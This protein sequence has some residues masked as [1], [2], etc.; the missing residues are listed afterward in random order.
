VGGMGIAGASVA[1]STGM[2]SPVAHAKSELDRHASCVALGIAAAVMRRAKL[3]QNGS[4][5]ALPG[6]VC[7]SIESEGKLWLGSTLL[8]GS[9]M[10]A[11][12]FTNSTSW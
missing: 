4:D 7:E 8:A 3:P 11:A 12:M 2:A 5:S 6:G 10:S 9:I 1:S